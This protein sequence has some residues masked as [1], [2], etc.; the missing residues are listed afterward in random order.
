MT[1]WSNTGG[2][3]PKDGLYTPLPCACGYQGSGTKNF[4]EALGA[5]T[6][7]IGLVA[8]SCEQNL[9]TVD[10]VLP[11]TEENIGW[12]KISGGKPAKSIDYGQG[13]I[14]TVPEKLP[15]PCYINTRGCLEP[16]VTPDPWN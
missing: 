9:Q 13:F 1:D 15:K 5:N 6:R 8:L 7:E 2:Y 3:V 4:Y 10:P 12:N 16:D 14:V 11:L